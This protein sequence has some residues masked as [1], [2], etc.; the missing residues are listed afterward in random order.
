MLKRLC[1]LSIWVAFSCGPVA[2]AVMDHSL[3][4]R[5]D[6][7]A[8]WVMLPFGNHTETPQAGLR[9]EAITET[10]LRSLGVG[11]LRQFPVTPAPDMLIEPTDPKAVDAAIAW[12][13]AQQA[14]YAVTGSVDEWR[15]KVGVDGEPA[16][17]V[18]LRLID[19][20][21]SQVVWSAGG[22]RTGWSREAV[23]AVA[24]KLIKA[25]LTQALPTS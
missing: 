18:S 16:V 9:A 1:L 22:G 11:D 25:L 12:A 20:Q 17:G 6:R 14:R 24:Q 10:V 3:A 4:P 19:L 15:Y 2:C 23:S 13:K 7:G 8:K 5:V 21:T